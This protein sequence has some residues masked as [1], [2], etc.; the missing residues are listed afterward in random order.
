M[1]FDTPDPKHLEHGLTRIRRSLRSFAEIDG[2]F[3]FRLITY[4]PALVIIAAVLVIELGL[5]GIRGGTNSWIP[6]VEVSA[7]LG[8]VLAGTVWFGRRQ[9]QVAARAMR[10]LNAAEA[11]RRTISAIG[12]G[13]NWDLDINRIFARFSNDLTTLIKYDRLVITTARSDGRMQLEFVAGLQVP[14]DEIGATVM[15]VVGSP[16]G[17]LSPVDYGLHSQMTVPIAAIDGIIT[18]RSRDRGAYGPHAVET[19]RQVVAQISP[20]IS[21][22]IHYQESQHR[23]MERTA[24][25][26]IGRAATQQIDLD[27]ILMVVSG[28]LSNLMKFDHLGAILTNPDGGQATVVCW[29]TEGLLGLNVNDKVDL[30]D[31]RNVSGVRSG[32]GTDPLRLGTEPGGETDDQRLWMQVPM[33]E[34]SNLLGVI[35]VSAQVGVTLGEDEADLLQRVANQIAPAIKNAQLTAELTWAVEERRA[36]ATIGRA[37][38][39]EREMKR[40]FAVVASELESIMSCDRFVATLTEPNSKYVEIVYS[41]GLAP[42]KGVVGDRIPGPTDDQRLELNSRHVILRNQHVNSD[43]PVDP[44]GDPIIRSSVQVVLG[45]LT[46]PMGYLSL[47][48]KD[49]DA[50]SMN[51]IEFFEGIARQIT[52]PLKN[53]R[54]FELELALREQL[55]LQNQ[56]LQEANAAKSRFLSTVSHELKTPLTIISGFIDLMIDGADNFTDEHGETLGI[57]RKNATQLGLLINDVLDISRVEAGNL[58][59]EPSVFQVNELVGE[60]EKGFEQLLTVK[61]QKLTLS[62][63]DHAIW[64][65]ADRNR[66]SQL[67]TN[68]LSN[69]HKYSGADSEIR[70]SVAIEDE[71]ITVL[72]EDEGI[73]ISEEDQKQLFTAFFRAENEATREAGGTGLGLVVAKSIADLHGGDLWINS[74]ENQGT[75]VGFKL[76]GVTSEPEVNPEAEAK[77]AL[78][79]QRSRLFPNTDWER[80]GESA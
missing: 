6:L 27:S 34:A 1:T 10:V 51:N 17:L 25:A 29:S 44:E 8:S 36:I 60:L 61:D 14:E 65:K 11:E 9:A 45:D 20:G 54:L 70:L 49:P 16:D 69:A 2:A 39:T 71:N 26:E 75:T 42:D 33:G 68:L 74:V 32:R 55:D 67:I 52:P 58:R 15:S 72:I 80:I 28:T 77:L 43:F 47:Y 78:L 12:I 21:N 4:S 3:R 30:D 41:Q 62:M 48:S 5:A 76:P 23:V 35:V 53:A 59:I 73:G 38:S 56:E 79:A 64:L 37:A 63:P 13:S 18:L 50:Y 19:M 40:I 22:A 31:A 7:V 66:V 57:I 46:E 24:L